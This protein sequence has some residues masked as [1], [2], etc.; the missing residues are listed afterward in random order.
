[1]KRIFSLLM[2]SLSVSAASAADIVQPLPPEVITR[3]QV[4]RIHLRPGEL[5]QVNLTAD[6]LY[7]ILASEIAA[8]RGYYDLASGTLLDLA[9]DTLDARLA[10]RAFQFSMAD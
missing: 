6:I 10:R 5:P 1:M 8:Q 3:S 7:R 2:A 4:E 9:R